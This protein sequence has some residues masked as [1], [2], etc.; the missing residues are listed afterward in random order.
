LQGR[1]FSKKHVQESIA[2]GLCMPES[3]KVD[4]INV[5]HEWEMTDFVIAKPGEIAL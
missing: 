3:Q 2:D 4:L 1:I 5:C